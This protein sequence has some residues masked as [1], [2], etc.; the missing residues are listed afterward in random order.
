MISQSQFRKQRRILARSRDDAYMTYLQGRLAEH[1]IAV[2]SKTSFEKSCQTRVVP[3]EAS[4][5]QEHI[6]E[7]R[8]QHDDCRAETGVQ[9]DTCP[10][11]KTQV[12]SLEALPEQKLR[13][14]VVRYSRTH[15]DINLDRLCGVT[16]GIVKLAK[17]RKEICD[18]AIFAQ[19]EL[20]RVL[21][22][23][24]A[25]VRRRRCRSCREGLA[26]GPGN[27][28][29]TLCFACYSERRVHEGTT[30]RF[31]GA[32][33]DVPVPLVSQE[34]GAVC[35]SAS[36]AGGPSGTVS[37]HG[38]RPAEPTSRS[39]DPESAPLPVSPVAPGSR[40]R[41]YNDRV[42]GYAT[43]VEEI[44]PSGQLR[45]RTFDSLFKRT[46]SWTIATDDFFIW[47]ENDG[48][49]KWPDGFS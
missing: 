6:M 31:A 37:G 41:V 17:T 27:P 22:G 48:S 32:D 18:V 16:A 38:A 7:V 4:E 26:R 34:E 42:C 10:S 3:H 13:D 19:A 33:I 23:Q 9:T 45:V 43:I 44:L 39:L 1:H 21:S 20:S 24:C 35:D 36:F 49:S 14:L 8:V 11:V 47:F 25:P 12:K 40:G 30:I 29:R 46:I 15:Q 28:S 2:M 5:E